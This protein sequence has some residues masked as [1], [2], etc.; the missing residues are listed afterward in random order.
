MEEI[1]DPDIRILCSPDHDG[2]PI[3]VDYTPKKKGGSPAQLVR[4]APQY[5]EV[6]MGNWTFS[7]AAD[8]PIKLTADCVDGRRLPS[9]RS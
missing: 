5:V 2:E 4:V 7:I 3:E 1:K 8:T 6:R 9:S